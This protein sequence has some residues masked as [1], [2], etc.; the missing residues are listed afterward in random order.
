LDLAADMDHV[1]PAVPAF[2]QPTSFLERRLTTMI[3]GSRR[4]GIAATAA[5]AIGVVLLGIAACQTPA[6]TP[7]PAPIAA[8]I[9]LPDGIGPDPLIFV[10]GQRVEGPPRE[11]LQRYSPDDIESIEIIKGPYAMNLYGDEAANGVIVIVLK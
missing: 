8:E 3:I 7:S 5:S 2:A 11:L 1:A 10:D 4:K 9:R 6:P